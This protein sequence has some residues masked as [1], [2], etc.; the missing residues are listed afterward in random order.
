MPASTTGPE[1][2]I[3][4]DLAA[5][6]S[7]MRS[8]AT[9]ISRIRETISLAPVRIRIVK[10]ARD[11]TIPE[12]KAMIEDYYKTRDVAYPSDIADAL[13]ISLETVVAALGELKKEGRVRSV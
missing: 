4:E 5:M 6:K 2:D 10:E 12:A 11:A 3:M 1:V 8:M 13:F 9:E 7:Q